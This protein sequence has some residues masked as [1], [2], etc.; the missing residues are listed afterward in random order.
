VLAGPTAGQ[1]PPCG[2]DITALRAHAVIKGRSCKVASLA[3]INLSCVVPFLWP[4]FAMAMI[5]I[6]A[7]SLGPFEFSGKK[8]DAYNVLWALVFGFATLNILGLAFKRFE[9][10][11]GGLNFGEMLAIMVVLVSV[12]LLGWEMMYLFKLLPIRL[13]SR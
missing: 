7:G 12:V 9:P 8:G 10:S 5:Y 2:N 6:S 1:S 3:T 13:P 11:H 4:K